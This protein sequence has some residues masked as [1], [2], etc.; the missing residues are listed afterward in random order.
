L[1]KIWI[2][3]VSGNR[4]PSQSICSRYTISHLVPRAKLHWD[5][6]PKSH[7]GDADYS[8]ATEAKSS[9][10]RIISQGA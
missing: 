3:T 5:V 7:S 2:K 8:H 10:R 1:Q 6:W 9:S 4:N